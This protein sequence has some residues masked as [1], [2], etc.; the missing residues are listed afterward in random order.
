MHRQ[1]SPRLL[2]ACALA[3]SVR[4]F[5]CVAW[6]VLGSVYRYVRQGLAKLLC[7]AP[8]DNHACAIQLTFQPKGGLASSGDLSDGDAYQRAHRPNCC[9]GCGAGSI[10]GGASHQPAGLRVGN[11]DTSGSKGPV[12]SDSTSDSTS[13]TSGSSTSTSAGLNRFSIV[14]HCFRRLLPH[15][16]KSRSSHDVVLLCHPCRDKAQVQAAP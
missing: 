10:V 11:G 15:A 14:P 8:H 9:V 2:W 7:A 16:V 12:N 5:D 4:D 6:R 3:L 1:A 13:S